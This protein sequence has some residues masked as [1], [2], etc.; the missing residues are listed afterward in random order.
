MQTGETTQLTDGKFLFNFFLMVDGKLYA[1]AAREFCNA[2]QP[3]LFDVD[4][5]TFTYR[6]EEDDD[7]EH[8]SFSYDRYEDAF[9]IV[10][11]RL[12]ETRTHRV[13]AE[14]HIEP[15]TISWLSKDFKDAKK[16]F[17]TEDFQIQEV[18]RLDE[19]HI[20]MTAEPHMTG[21]RS[22][23]VL[24]IETQEVT[25]MEIPGIREVHF[26]CTTGDENTIFVK[27][28]DFVPSWHL[29]RYELDTQTL[30]QVE[31][32]EKLRQIVDLQ[33]TYQSCGPKEQTI[34]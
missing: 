7:T 30:T 28:Q 32:P 26:F 15:K 10:T 11:D 13:C 9:L 19:T 4:K 8:L 2:L 18:S 1:T 23:K 29:Y 22:F 21:K 27:G 17:F 25:D 3:A 34:Q 16:I 14:T 24:D 20:L 31:F 6:N 12:S 5:K 33:I